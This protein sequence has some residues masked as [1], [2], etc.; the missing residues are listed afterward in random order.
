MERLTDFWGLKKKKTD[1]ISSSNTIR[2]KWIICSIVMVCL[3]LKKRARLVMRHMWG[4]Y[5]FHPSIILHKQHLNGVTRICWN[6]AK[7]LILKPKQGK[8][9][10][11]SNKV[12]GACVLSRISPAVQNHVRSS[13]LETVKLPQGGS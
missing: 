4:F 13:R 12:P 1:E 5:A 7:I 6:R 3:F 10:R 2:A 11:Y 9:R 8:A